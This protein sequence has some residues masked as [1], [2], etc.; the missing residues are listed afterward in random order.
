MHS[1]K[2]KLSMKSMMRYLLLFTCICFVTSCATVHPTNFY[3]LT[4]PLPE[5][6][7]NQQISTA[8]HANMINISVDVPDG[9]K[10]PQI[11][12]NNK[13]D[14][15]LVLLEHHRWLS[16]FDE[17]LNDAL[18][19]GIHGNTNIQALASNNRYQISVQLLQMD[20]VLSDRVATHFQWKIRRHNR[21]DK[22]S[23]ASELVCE[24]SA[25]KPTDT[26]VTSAVEAMQAIVQDLTQIISQQIIEL[27]S[28]QTDKCN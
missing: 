20:T 24:F 7:R 19:S 12:I 11:V 10:R 25:N 2:D 27:E 22:P 28:A 3:T 23:N 16:A 18:N 17:E 26:S 14:S 9:L 21:D 8:K 1:H 13:N 4:K 15:S 6:A 5:A